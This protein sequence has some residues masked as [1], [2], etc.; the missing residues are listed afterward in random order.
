M[1]NG[2]FVRLHYTG[3]LPDGT[4]FDTTDAE[5]A[6]KAGIDGTKKFHPVTICVGQG[7]LLKG[8]D[9]E[10][11]KHDAS[12]TAT[13]P[14]EKAFGKKNPELLKI[15]PT[16]QLHKQ[17][18]NP[19]PGMQL[20]IDGAYGIVRSSSSGRTVVD[21][22]HPLA[23]QDVTYD[24]RIMAKVDDPQ[25]QIEALIDALGLPYESVA[26]AQGSATI[27][28][29]QLYPQPVLQAVQ[30]RIGKLTSVKTVSFEQGTKPEK[31]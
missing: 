2:D 21:F 6:K 23:S 14:S 12:F 8:L 7:M 10:L 5:V 11:L 15:I 9:E 16:M 24:V 19:Q 29:P 4:I 3:K 18:I 27:K 1:K 26:V 22:N 20:N 13:I 25:E 31:D 30:D 17:Q 28:L